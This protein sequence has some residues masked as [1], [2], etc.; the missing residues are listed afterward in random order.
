[1]VDDDTTTKLS[2]LEF[3]VLVE[4]LE[5]PMPLVLKVPSPGRTHSERA[6]LVETA[7][8]SMRRRGLGR[9]TA[10][11]PRL[12][13]MLRVLC[14][15]DREVDGR[16]WLAGS[17]R[18]LAA[19]R[20]GDPQGVLA[21]K[22]GETLALREIPAS[23]LAR[24]AVSVLPPQP[25]GPGRSVSLRSRDLDSAAAET[26]S[27]VEHLASA[28]RKRGVRS[29]DAEMLT[30]MVTGAGWRGQFG[31]AAKDQLG[32]RV[33]GSYVVGFFDTEHGRYVQLRRPSP[34]AELWSTIAPVDQRRLLAH[35]EELL[36]E[37]TCREPS[38]IGLG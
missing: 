8:R 30:R 36:A 31:A 29:N 4:Q 18:L 32:Q 37:V 7:W 17:C 16:L 33:R 9:P 35:V 23:G 25:A 22:T 14:Q 19:A 21:V 26:G 5:L 6:E 13:R 28:L 2:T 34:S 15:P 3:D 20:S 38:P 24:A 27:T 12:A 1:M 11:A 10:V